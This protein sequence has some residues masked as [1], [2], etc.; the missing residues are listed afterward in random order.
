MPRAPQVSSSFSNFS[1]DTAETE[2]DHRRGR[3]VTAPAVTRRGYRES[4]VE[5]SE[6]SAKLVQWGGRQCSPDGEMDSTLWLASKRRETLEIR[7]QLLSYKQ[8][9]YE[10]IY[11]LITGIVLAGG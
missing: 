9:L 2:V 6:G 11:L 3:N 1:N 4:C 7:G 10:S 5:K 8:E